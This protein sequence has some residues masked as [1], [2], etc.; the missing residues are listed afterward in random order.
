MADEMAAQLAIRFLPP[1]ERLRGGRQTGVDTEIVEQTIGL[2]PPQIA[3]IGL[4]RV[5]E[6]SR[7]KAHLRHGESAYFHGRVLTRELNRFAESWSFRWKYAMVRRQ[8]RR[9]SYLLGQKRRGGA[10]RENRREPTAAQRFRIVLK[11]GIGIAYILSLFPG[12]VNR[13]RGWLLSLLKTSESAFQSA[14]ESHK[15]S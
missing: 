2:K 9:R 7:Q 6:R 14:G 13:Q 1:A 8:R 12:V 11:H 15:R 10:C 4:L 3:E 5:L